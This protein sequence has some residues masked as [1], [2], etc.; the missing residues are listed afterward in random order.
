MEISKVKVFQSNDTE[1][2]QY[3]LSSNGKSIILKFK[4]V[5]LRIMGSNKACVWY[6]NED[7]IIKLHKFK[8]NLNKL[9][10]DNKEFIKENSGKEISLSNFL[11]T[12]QNGN[13]T[14]YTRISDFTYCYNEKQ[15]DINLAM[16]DDDTVL[17]CDILVKFESIT[18]SD[19]DYCYVNNSLYQ[20]LIKERSAMKS[21]LLLNQDFN[22]IT[23]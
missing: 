16:Y 22:E 20:V 11:Y 9:I 7:E 19:S 3:V 5:N 17:R 13:C 14:F 21:K 6:H 18:D 12:S 15:E 2:H 4:D 23:F 8:E 10:E 1:R